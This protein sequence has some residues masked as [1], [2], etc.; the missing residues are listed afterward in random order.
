VSNA[1]EIGVAA[2]FALGLALLVFVI[3]PATKDPQ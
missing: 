3:M 2:P 1:Y